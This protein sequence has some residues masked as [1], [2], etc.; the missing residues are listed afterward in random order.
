MEVSFE[1]SVIVLPPP[2]SWVLCAK[3]ATV[4]KGII[5]NRINFSVV[6][7]IS[8]TIY[9]PAVAP[10]KAHPSS[11]DSQLL[12]NSSLLT[13]KSEV[14]YPVT[15]DVDDGEHATCRLNFAGEI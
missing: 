7:R 9:L 1:L 8:I 6:K 3:G 11:P 5:G 12:S 4:G 10:G 2:S 15:W 14:E 13:S